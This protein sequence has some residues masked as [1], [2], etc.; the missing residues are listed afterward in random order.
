[1]NQTLLSLAFLGILGSAGGYTMYRAFSGSSI[2]YAD[3]RRVDVRD[4]SLG[5][6]RRRF[7]DYHFRNRAITRQ[8]RSTT[9]GGIGF[10]K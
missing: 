7:F 2:P 5:S 4:G 8:N 1:M 10:G 9:G 3:G 6:G